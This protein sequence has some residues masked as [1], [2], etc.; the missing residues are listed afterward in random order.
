MNQLEKKVSPNLTQSRRGQTLVGKGWWGFPNLE[1]VARWF[2]FGKNTSFRPPRGRNFGDCHHSCQCLASPRSALLVILLLALATCKKNAPTES[3]P[4][5]VYYTCSMDPQVMEKRPGTCPICKMDLTRIEIDPN[6]KQG[7]VKLSDEQIRLANIQTDT[8]RLHPLGEEIT[9][10]A[11]L[12]ENQNFVNVVSARISGRIERL[13]VRNI[14][15]PVQAGQPLFEIYSEQLAAAQQDYLLAR[16]SQKR[17]AETEPNFTRIAEAARQ[18]L[19]LWGMTEA[20]IAELE[21]SGKPANTLVFYSNYSGIAT[22]TPVSEGDYVVEG[23]PVL[24]LAD[25]QTLWA[26]AQ[27]YVSDLPFLAKGGG[28]AMVEIP[29]FSEKKLRG[30]VS[31]VNPALENSSKI[32]MIRVEILNAGGDLQPGMQAWLTLKSKTRS[33]IAVPTNALIWG[34]D[35]ASI[36]LRKP[37]GAF[38]SRMVVPGTTNRDF[39]EIKEGLLAGEA[40]VI[41]GAYLLH[42]ELVF[43]KG[44]NPMAGHNMSG[45]GGGHKGH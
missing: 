27:L 5:N 17:F 42:S 22:E 7:E 8:A 4:E 34:K 19:L 39:T 16:Q 1:E 11:T 25:L 36:W 29:S 41:S 15:E 2:V 14:G 35:G 18:K 45:E 31:F 44:T 21:Q 9:L 13:F 24:R 38:E 32:V 33:S 28:G 40:V 43:K 20:Q 30:K 10:S 26:E 3:V 37:Y 12:K 6:Q 23:S